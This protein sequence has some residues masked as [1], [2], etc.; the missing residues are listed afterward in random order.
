MGS[1]VS[2]VI[3]KTLLEIGRPTLDKTVEY[4][5]E[6][7]NCRLQDCYEHPEYLNSVLQYI[8]GEGG[9]VI[10]E[11]IKK[12]LEDYSYDNKIAFLIKTINR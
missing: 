3:E 6:N 2:L 9:N 5:K 8:F 12:Q 11:S 1:L 4:L 7:Y 10:I